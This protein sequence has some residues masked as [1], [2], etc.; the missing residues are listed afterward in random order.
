MVKEQSSIFTRKLTNNETRVRHEFLEK[1]YLGELPRNILLKGRLLIHD[2]YRHYQGSIPRD[3]RPA[4]RPL[5][6]CDADCTVSLHLGVP[7][8]HVIADQISKETLSLSD[9]H[10]HWDLQQPLLSLLMIVASMR[11]F[12][13]LFL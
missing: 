10:H 2:E 1:E 7:C 6:D 11:I 5:G 4:K 9:I 3:N 12:L 8:R 13:I